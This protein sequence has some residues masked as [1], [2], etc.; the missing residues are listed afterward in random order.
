VG[1]KG[2]G[3][4]W[5]CDGGLKKGGVHGGISPRVSAEVDFRDAR[6]RSAFSFFSFLSWD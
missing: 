6:P 3:G 4:W 5:G 2:K 1:Q